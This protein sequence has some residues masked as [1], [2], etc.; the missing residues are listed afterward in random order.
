LDD[1][2]KICSLRLPMMIIREESKATN[3]L[4][5]RTATPPLHLRRRIG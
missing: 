2:P 4:A 3:P 1:H 5:F